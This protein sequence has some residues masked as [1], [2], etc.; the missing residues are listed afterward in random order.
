ML[1]ICWGGSGS[2]CV[3]LNHFLHPVD[4]KD[5]SSTPY[6]Q[7]RYLINLGWIGWD[8]PASNPIVHPGPDVSAVL[9]A[10]AQ[11]GLSLQV[12]P[13]YLP[14]SLA[15]FCALSLL[16]HHYCGLPDSQ[17]TVR[18][19]VGLPLK[20][21]PLWLLH[22]LFQIVKAVSLLLMKLPFSLLPRLPPPPPSQDAPTI[23]REYARSSRMSSDACNAALSIL[24]HLNVPPRM[25]SRPRGRHCIGRWVGT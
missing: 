25:L 15:L 20:R 16:L 19:T 7:H 12:L 22:S 4:P 9:T 10:H 21:L 5:G 23:L 18:I 3:C 24:T 11:T 6:R 13:L 1:G 14:L 17:K 8:P 2:L